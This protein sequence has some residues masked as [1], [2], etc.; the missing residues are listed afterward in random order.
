MNMGMVVNTYSAAVEKGIIAKV[1]NTMFQ[2]PVTTHRPNSP[3][4]AREK[5]IGTPIAKVI[6]KAK[7]GKIIIVCPSL[8]IS[9]PLRR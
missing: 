8:E 9:P 4:P 5:A 6:I 1:L 2:S 3:A 7:K